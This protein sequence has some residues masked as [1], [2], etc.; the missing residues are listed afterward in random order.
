MGFKF[1]L[2]SVCSTVGREVHAHRFGIV[3][4]PSCDQGPGEDTASDFGEDR[5][6]EKPRCGDSSAWLVHA[7]FRHILMS[8]WMCCVIAMPGKPAGSAVRMSVKAST[9]PVLEP[10]A[11]IWRG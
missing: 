8:N 2:E 10:M 11:M 3:G 6:D 4:G 5:C 9:P 7:C 1:D